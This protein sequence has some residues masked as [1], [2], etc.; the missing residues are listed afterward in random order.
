MGRKARHLEMMAASPNTMFAA[1]FVRPNAVFVR[2]SYSP[3][4]LGEIVN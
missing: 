3:K 1:H 2:T 4:P